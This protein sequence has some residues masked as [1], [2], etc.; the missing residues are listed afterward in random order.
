[1]ETL[2]IVLQIANIWLDVLL[3]ALLVRGWRK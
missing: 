2:K 3:I 1:M